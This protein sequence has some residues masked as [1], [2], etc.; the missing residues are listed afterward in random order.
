MEDIITLIQQ[1]GFPAAV[2]V[3]LLWRYDKRLQELGDVLNKILI[4]IE[5]LKGV[6]EDGA[7]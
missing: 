1:V 2:A 3:F 5:S 7:D 6:I 4:A